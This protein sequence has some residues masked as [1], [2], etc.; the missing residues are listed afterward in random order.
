M[1]ILKQISVFF[2]L[3]VFTISFSQ[4]SSTKHAMKVSETILI[5]NTA[6]PKAYYQKWVAGVQ[7]GGSGIDVYIHK[8]LL[9]QKT[10][11]SIYF[12]GKITAAK[13]T[14]NMYVGYFKDEVN[15]FSQEPETNTETA[16]FDTENTFPFHLKSNE[17]VLSYTEAGIVKYVKLEGLLK[18]QSPDYPSAP[19]Q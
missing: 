15:H 4:C 9:A 3:V 16:K 10:A 6:Q 14:N 19:Q 12:R 8:S 11:D 17:A 2:L 7:G 18:K 1:S 5:E 13:S